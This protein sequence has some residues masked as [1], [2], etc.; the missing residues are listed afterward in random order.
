MFPLDSRTV[1]RLAEVIVD[2]GGPYERKGYQLEELLRG[3]GWTEPPEY[4]GSPRIPWLREQLTER[5]DDRPAIERLI[6]RV[7]DPI[8]YDDGPST[9]DEF[10]VV[11]NEKL[12]AEGLVVT[13]VAGRPVLGEL[14]AD[15][16]KPRY[17]VPPDLRKRLDALINDTGAVEMLSRR[18]EETQVCEVGGAYTMA[19][20]G[21]GSFVEGLLLTVLTERDAEIKANGFA[22]S[23]QRNQRGRHDRA[24]L[25]QLIDIAHAK[26]W[27]QLDAKAFAHNVRDF[28]NFIHPRKEMTEQP[29]FDADSV[30][31]CWAPVHAILNDLEQK[32]GPTGGR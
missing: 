30:M 10:R 19:I 6:C 12:A 32:L 8:E 16:E 11:I 4:D 26:D 2:M 14:A 17:T 23:E 3:A 27:I 18:V 21:I 20:I 1:D 9:A 28:R 31:L 15:G 24:T 5:R 25:Q 29:R 13:L 7:C 22:D